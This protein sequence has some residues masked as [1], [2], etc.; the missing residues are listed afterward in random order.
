MNNVH[1][2]FAGPSNAA[3]RSASGM[4]DADRDREYEAVRIA[5]STIE[6][7]LADLDRAAALSDLRRGQL[8]ELKDAIADFMPGRVGWE[9]SIN[10]ARRNW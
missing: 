1:S 6:H 8:L 2:L 7:T 3:L 5:F 4:S 9:E 10:A